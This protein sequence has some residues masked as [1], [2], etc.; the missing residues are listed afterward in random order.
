MKILH[1]LRNNKFGGTQVLASSFDNYDESIN[2]YY[3][4]EKNPDSFFNQNVYYYSNKKKLHKLLKVQKFDLILC[5]TGFSVLRLFYPLINQKLI[6]SCGS[7]I[8]KHPKYFLYSVFSLIFKNI[9]IVAPSKVVEKSLKNYFTQDISYI[10]N[11]IRSIFFSQKLLLKNKVSSVV[12]V[13]RID[14]NDPARNWELFCQTSRLNS[15]TALSFTA[16]G[17]GEKK[18]YLSLK[19]PKISFTGNLNEIELIKTLKKSDIFLHLNNS[20]EGFGIALYEAMSQGCIPIAPDIP[21]N[22]EII[23]NGYNGFLYE[24]VSEIEQIL[25][26]IRLFNPD[27]IQTLSNNANQSI[28]NKYSIVNFLKN[29]KSII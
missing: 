27:Q 11:P 25:I 1:I 9:K 26:E 13:G 18:S 21:I 7:I 20:T 16:I 2:Y 3:F 4:L 6:I 5:Y 17:D 22:N 28:K 10:P 12:M 19:Y 24:N 23:I 14:E 15:L 29:I 8:P